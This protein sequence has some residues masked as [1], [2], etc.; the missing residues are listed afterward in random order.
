MEYALQRLLSLSYTKYIDTPLEV[1]SK[2]VW[3]VE[4][5]PLHEQ[6]R[7]VPFAASRAAEVTGIANR[8]FGENYLHTEN[9]LAM[10]GQDGPFYM[11]L[12]GRE[13]VGYCAFLHEPAALTAERMKLPPAALLPYAGRDGRV[14]CTKTMAVVERYRKT[15]LAEMLFARCLRDSE[16]AGIASAW[17]SAWKIGEVVPMDRI[18]RKH[19]FAVY[20]TVPDLWYDAD[21]DYR[22]NVC[23]GPCRCT[24]VIYHRSFAG[25]GAAAT[26]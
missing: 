4:V 16:A 5:I 7:I 1:Q 25:K 12:A 24:G 14:C 11:A 22:C 20:A 6:P 2:R 8:S 23:G 3:G 15:G 21:S 10:A 9:V 17:G 19:A 18:F 26:P 13:V